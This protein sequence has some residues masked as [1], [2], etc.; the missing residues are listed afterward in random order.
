MTRAYNPHGEAPKHFCEQCG[1][2]V[3]IWYGATRLVLDAT[4]TTTGPY[5][6]MGTRRHPNDIARSVHHDRR[7]G[8]RTHDCDLNG[9]TND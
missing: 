1:A 5:S 3:L 6:R 7:D 2:H 4:P 8:Y 9:A